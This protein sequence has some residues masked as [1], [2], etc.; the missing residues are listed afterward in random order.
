MDVEKEL[1]ICCIKKI[2]QKEQLNYIPISGINRVFKGDGY[3]EV[4]HY[5]L[6][7]YIVSKIKNEFLTNCN[8]IY[9]IRLTFDENDCLIIEVGHVKS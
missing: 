3:D 4:I 1:N 5:S 9:D 7:R 6:V 2:I 8:L